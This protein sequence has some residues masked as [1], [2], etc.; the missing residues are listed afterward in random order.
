MERMC[1][2]LGLDPRTDHVDAPLMEAPY[3]ESKT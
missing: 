1:A 2:T 3:G